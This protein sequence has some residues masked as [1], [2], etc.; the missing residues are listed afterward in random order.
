MARTQRPIYWR[1]NDD[2]TTSPMTNAE[3]RVYFGALMDGTPEQR[4]KR[5]IARSERGGILVSTIF[6]CIDVCAFNQGTPLL[7]ETAVWNGNEEI[8]RDRYHTLA[9]ARAGHAALCARCFTTL[10]C[11]N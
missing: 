6:L 3:G 11:A 10:P 5:I 4:A 2:G 1:L 7:F 8:E 9:L